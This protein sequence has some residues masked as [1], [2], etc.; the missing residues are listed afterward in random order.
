[1]KICKICK[2]EK[3]Y[4][5]FGRRKAEKDGLDIYCHTCRSEYYKNKKYDRR[6]YNSKY[7]RISIEDRKIYLRNYMRSYRINKLGIVKHIPKNIHEI[8]QAKLITRRIYKI[9]ARVLRYKKETRISKTEEL[10]GWTRLEFMYK[11][12]EGLTDKHIDH[13][14]PII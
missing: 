11:F 12:R 6:I 5:E 1:M 9:L 10:L 13:K 8:K 4:E 3:S 14:I 2:I 7:K